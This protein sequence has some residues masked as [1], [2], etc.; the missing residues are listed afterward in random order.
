MQL[1][2]HYWHYY[3]YQILQQTTGYCS[4]KA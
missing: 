2:Y 4:S 1:C 3:Y